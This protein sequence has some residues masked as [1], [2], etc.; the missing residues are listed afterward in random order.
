MFRLSV[1]E[2]DSIFR[3]KFFEDDLEIVPGGYFITCGNLCLY[4]DG[5]DFEI[6]GK[7][8]ENIS[9]KTHLEFDEYCIF[10]DNCR[11]YGLPNGSGWVNELPWVVSFV[12]MFNRILSEI[13]V[14]RIEK[15]KK[16]KGL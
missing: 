8:G 11:E 16:A 14:Y 15:N 9:I 5:K 6:I 10:W 1:I 2:F 3:D 12:K 13:E 7:D 4:K